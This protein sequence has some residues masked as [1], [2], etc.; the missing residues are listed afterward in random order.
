MEKL[1]TL[2]LEERIHRKSSKI[3]IKFNFNKKLLAFIRSI[4]GMYWSATLTAWYI[5]KSPENLELIYSSFKGLAIINNDKL[6]N[7]TK[8][9]RNFNEGQKQLLNGYFKYLKGKRYSESTIKTYTFFVADF[10]DFHAT[11]ELV[12][13]TNRSVEEFLEVVFIK[14]NYSVSS[15][16]QFISAL[17]IFINYCPET[18]I[19]D[20]VLERPKKSRKLPSVLSQE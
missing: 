5:E 20:L 3:L 10:I 14:R 7:N 2:F 9:Q 1:T 18:N 17:K 12:A 6:N 4:K 15:Q 11:K 16:R 13:L 19:N 8:Q